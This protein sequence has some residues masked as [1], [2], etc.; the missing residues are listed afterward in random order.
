MFGLL[1]FEF[2]RQKTCIEKIELF[3]KKKKSQKNTRHKTLH[4]HVMPHY[5]HRLKII[6]E[7]YFAD[8]NS[9]L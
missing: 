6:W 5:D 9:F 7:L 8:S 4:V 2:S 3:K 1:N